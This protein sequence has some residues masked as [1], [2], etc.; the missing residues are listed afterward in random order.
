MEI[1]PLEARKCLPMNAKILNVEE[2]E[3]F[4]KLCL[5]HI[6]VMFVDVGYQ[7]RNQMLNGRIHG[8]QKRWA[9]PYTDII[10]VEQPNCQVPESQVASQLPRQS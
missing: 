1:L 8:G 2:I 10:Q 7:G 9:R 4:Q 6:T 3:K 5:R